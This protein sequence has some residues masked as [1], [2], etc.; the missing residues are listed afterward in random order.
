M[1]DLLLLYFKGLNCSIDTSECA[2]EPCLHGGSCSEPEAG[3]FKCTCPEGV[4]GVLCEVMTSA[5]FTGGSGL[6]FPPF[7]GGLQPGRRKKR[8]TEEDTADASDD[9]AI[10][11]ILL[12]FDMSTSFTSGVILFASGVSGTISISKMY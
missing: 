4:E 5:T 12:T 3:T 10:T 6:V 1:A 7:F 2:L 9:E 11:E 8:E